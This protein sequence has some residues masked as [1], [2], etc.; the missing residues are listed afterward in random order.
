MA[1]SAGDDFDFSTLSLKDLIEAR[2]LYHFH[3]MSKANVVGTA[4]G[5]Y[6]IRDKE[7]W[8]RARGEGAA[9]KDKLTYPRTFANSQVR[10]YSWPC[11]LVLVRKW[12]D[13]GDFGRKGEPPPWCVVPKRLYLPDG[14]A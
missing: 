9:P 7:N 14:R 2:D 5:L 4:V 10:D 3:L 8:P 6:L 13:E 11:I 1:G 12:V